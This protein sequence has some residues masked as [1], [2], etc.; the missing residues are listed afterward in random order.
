MIGMGEIGG[1]M[2]KYAEIKEEENK[3]KISLLL[4]NL[5]TMYFHAET[6]VHIINISKIKKIVIHSVRQS[7]KISLTSL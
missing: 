5:C 4:T 3:T 6:H 7:L 1:E 2:E